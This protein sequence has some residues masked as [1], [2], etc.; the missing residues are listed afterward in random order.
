MVTRDS[1][2]DRHDAPAGD[3]RYISRA[4]LT[5][6]WTLATTS[7]CS[8]KVTASARSWQPSDGKSSAARSPRAKD[9]LALREDQQL[10]RGQGQGQ[11]LLCSVLGAVRVAKVRL[12]LVASIPEDLVTNSETQHSTNFLSLGTSGHFSPTSGTS[13]HHLVRQA[14]LS[15]CWPGGVAPLSL[16]LLCRLVPVR[17]AGATN[18]VPVT[19]SRSP[20]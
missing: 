10:I 14:E 16:P 20:F 2:C 6:Y 13:L 18:D 3:V 15:T 12:C 4:P 5:G 17:V 11:R 9:A 8:R 1:R 19:L 7:T